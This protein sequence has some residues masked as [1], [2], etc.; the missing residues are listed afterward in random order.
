MAHDYYSILEN[1]YTR[2]NNGLKRILKYVKKYDIKFILGSSSAVYDKVNKKILNENE[3]ITDN[4]TDYSK[5]IKVNEDI[6]L[7]SNIKA[8]IL[9]IAI[10]YGYGLLPN[11]FLYE[12]LSELYSGKRLLGY[13]YDKDV[14]KDYIHI[15]DLIYCIISAIK[16]LNTIKKCEIINIGT[17]INTPINVLINNIV[18]FINQNIKKYNI[19]IKEY[20]FKLCK[21]DYQRLNITKAKKIFKYK[22]TTNLN[23]LLYLSSLIHY[24]ESINI[25]NAKLTD[26]LKNKIN[27]LDNNDLQIFSKKYIPGFLTNIEIFDYIEYRKYRLNYSLNSDSIKTLA[28]YDKK[29]LEQ[30]KEEI[31]ERDM[32]LKKQRNIKYY[33]YTPKIYDTHEERIVIINYINKLLEK[34]KNMDCLFCKII[35]KEIPSEIIYEDEDILAFLDINPTTNGDTLIIPKTHYQD[36]FQVPDDVL[37]K[38]NNISKKLYKLYQEKLH[39]IGLTLSTNLDYGQEI[40]HFHVHFIPRY[41]NDEVSHLSNKEILKDLKEIKELLK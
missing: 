24:Y 5:A 29:K 39:C 6:V 10:P 2:L 33:L 7:N 32:T 21:S 12:L 40:K 3:K 30:K 25:V 19:E 34:E 27:K 4:A 1:D 37:G 11:T 9:R 26:R 22:P 28:S 20:N 41:E 36:V 16:Y 17:G 31:I 13:E 38:I 14:P 35:K 8:L 18:F 23:D 15:N